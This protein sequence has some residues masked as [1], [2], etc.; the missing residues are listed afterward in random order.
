[1]TACVCWWADGCV[2]VDFEEELGNIC[3]GCWMI[4]VCGEGSFSKLSNRLPPS[5]PPSSHHIHQ[6]HQGDQT[7]LIPDNFVELLP[8]SAQPPPS[9]SAEV[10]IFSSCSSLHY[11]A[12]PSP[13][14]LSPIL[15][16]HPLSLSSSP[17]LPL[18]PTP[19]LLSLPPILHLPLNSFTF[20]PLPPA[21]P[22]PAL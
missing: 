21:L 14:P 8:Q 1:M 17:M 13:P 3:K 9:P 4:C 10:T 7:G 16:S 12:P 20:P 19:L 22:S 11:S 2:C 18:P 6:V 5:S 15:P